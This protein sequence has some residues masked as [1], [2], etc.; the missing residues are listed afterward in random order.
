MA[1]H[2]ETGKWGEQIAQNMLISKGYTIV[3]TNWRMHHY[4]TD[5]IATKSN[6]II[7]VEVKTRTNNLVDPLHAIDK[8]K[9]S[10]I[11]K[12]ANVYIKMFNIKLEPQFDIINI[13][14]TQNN[15][16]IEHIADAFL[17]PLSSYR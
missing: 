17:A 1:K 12:S 2:N 8:K 15:Y 10:R 13:I 5:I 16:T 6:R 9:I 4:E 3:E 11:V 7:F 14:G